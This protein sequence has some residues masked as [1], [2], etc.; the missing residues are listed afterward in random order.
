MRTSRP[1]GSTAQACALTLVL[2]GAV[3]GCS[4]SQPADDHVMH[5]TENGEPINLLV[6][7]DTF[8]SAGMPDAKYIQR[9]ASEGVDIVL[10]V[11]PPTSNGALENEPQLVANAGM[12]YLNIAVDWNSPT[13]K[14]VEQFL[15]F[16][17]SH[18]DD[19]VFLHCQMN[20]R[21]TAFA[22]LH[23]VI[24]QGVEPQSA[25]EDVHTI[26]QP[27]HVWATLMNETLTNH[28]VD[29]TVEVPPPAE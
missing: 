14:D 23:R 12:T 13:Q 22:M 1:F 18:A 2:C 16:M 8:A 27:N 28:N 20:M 3:T 29:F 17:Q 24:N 15:S 4:N 9:L 25:M 19:N 7:N 10:N 26:W 11:A 21:A 6:Y 5:Q